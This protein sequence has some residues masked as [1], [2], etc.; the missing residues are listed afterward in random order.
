M[1]GRLQGPYVICSSVGHVA[2]S[3]PNLEKGEGGSPGWLCL[4]RP[5]ATRPSDASGGHKFSSW[6]GR[7]LV[8]D[9][10]RGE[11]WDQ[12]SP[13]ARRC[14]LSGGPEFGFCNRKIGRREWGMLSQGRP[15]AKAHI[16]IWT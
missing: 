9:G 5:A 13:A 14:G 2:S 10:V 8:S 6:V 12:E 15:A 4:G 3:T 16:S 1:E 7:V 11:G